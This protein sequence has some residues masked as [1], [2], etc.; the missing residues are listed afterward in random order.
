LVERNAQLR[1]PAVVDFIQSIERRR[2]TKKG[3]HSI[4]SVMR[5]GGELAPSLRALADLPNEVDRLHALRKTIQPYLQFVEEGRECDQTG[6]PLQHI[7]RYFR[8]T[9]TNAYKSIPGRSLMILVRDAAAENHPVIGIAA[10][11]S[12]IS[13]QRGRDRWIGWDGDSVVE[14]L[15]RSPTTTAAKWLHAQFNA[16]LSSIYSDDLRAEGV[17]TS[18]DIT[19]PTDEVLARLGRED[20]KAKER[21]RRFPHAASHKATQSYVAEQIDW[22]AQARTHLFR[23]KRSEKLAALLSVRMAFKAA[24]FNKPTKACLQKA[25]L[26][27]EFVAAVRTLARMIKADHIGVDMMDITVCGAVAPYNAL[28]G[29]N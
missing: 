14:S 29:A 9:W 4:F 11:G 17:C 15:I 22:K 25:L 2:L 26:R 1:D 6:L 8:H 5:D 24:G 7:W 12:S 18:L 10:L 27:S 21:H 23:S 3:W 28:L 19:H 16:Q 20:S 13:Q